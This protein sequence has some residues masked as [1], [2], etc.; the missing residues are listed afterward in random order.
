MVFPKKTYSPGTPLWR[1]VVLRGSQKPVKGGPQECHENR[2]PSAS[3]TYRDSI[4]DLAHLSCEK[5]KFQKNA[6]REG[7]MSRLFLP[8]NRASSLLEGP[9][10]GLLRKVGAVSGAKKGETSHLRE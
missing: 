9:F 7:G 4:F 3:W 1:M 6:I 10:F 8:L 5:S 2:P